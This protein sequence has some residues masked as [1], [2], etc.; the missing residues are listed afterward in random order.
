MTTKQDELIALR[1]G[2]KLAERS[3]EYWSKEDIQLLKRLYCQ[4]GIGISEI[5]LLLKRSEG[6]V[7]QQLTKMGLL[8]PQ[9]RH[10]TRKKKADETTELAGRCLCPHCSEKTCQNCGKE[11]FYAGT[12]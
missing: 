1:T 12:V 5:A 7:C 8:T 9:G 10:R 3:G 2:V 11:F 4:D 6:A